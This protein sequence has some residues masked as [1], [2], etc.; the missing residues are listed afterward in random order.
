[1]CPGLSIL[2]GVCI[3]QVHVYYVFGY[4]LG[5][6]ESFLFCLFMGARPIPETLFL[7]SLNL[8]RP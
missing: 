2:N 8:N 1:M 3:Q 7:T 4:Y 5:S 6:L